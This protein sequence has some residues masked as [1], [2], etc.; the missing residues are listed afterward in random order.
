MAGA[1]WPVRTSRTHASTSSG[2]AAGAASD[3]DAEGSAPQ[4]SRATATSHMRAAQV[5]GEA[6]GAAASTAAGAGG[7]APSWVP[8]RNSSAG[9]HGRMS[10]MSQR[11]TSGARTCRQV[12]LYVAPD[13]GQRGVVKVGNDNR[14]RMMRRH[15]ACPDKEHKSAALTLRTCPHALRTRQPHSGAHLQHCLARQPLPGSRTVSMRCAHGMPATAPASVKPPRKRACSTPQLETRRALPRHA[16]WHCAGNDQQLPV[17]SCKRPRR[18]C[19]RISCDGAMA[20]RI[21]IN[22]GQHTAMGRCGGV[23]DRGGHDAALRG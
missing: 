9:V 23:Q 4:S 13:V 17:T 20:V 1:A 7:A 18:R 11:A 6:P 2:P 5:A 22:R 19:W 10:Q 8:C 12:Q 3:A 16:C 15:Q 21:T 14:P